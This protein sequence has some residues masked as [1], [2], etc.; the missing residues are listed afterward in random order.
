MKLKNYYNVIRTKFMVKK[1]KGKIDL[2]DIS[3]ISMNC[4]GGTFYHDVGYKFLSPT[5][6]LF[7]TASDFIK[8]VNNLDYYLSLIP[9]VEM[10]E[11]YPIGTLDDIKIYFMHYYSCEEALKKWEERK[12]RINTDKIFVIMIEQNGFSKDDFE[13]FKKIKYPKILFVNK[14]EYRCEDSVYFSKYENEEYLPDIIQGRYYYKGNK[15]INAVRK[16]FE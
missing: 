16:A 2:S 9:V 4:I 5:I 8:L 11:K 14:K 13:N 7:F 3:L 10:G 6:N 1:V 12:N 15:L